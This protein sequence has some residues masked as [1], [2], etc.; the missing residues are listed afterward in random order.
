MSASAA[1][2]RRDWPRWAACG[3]AVLCA[4]A[5]AA[6]IVVNLG[7]PAPS[8]TIEASIV[9]DLAPIATS[10]TQ[11]SQDVAVGPQRPD[12]DGSPEVKS[13]DPTNEKAI[14]HVDMP[15]PVKETPTGAFA[16]SAPRDEKVDAPAEQQ[17]QDQ[18]LREKAPQLQAPAVTAVAPTHKPP[19]PATKKKAARPLQIASAPL[20]EREFDQRVAAPNQGAPAPV[21]RHAAADWQAAISAA[22]ERAKRYPTEARAHQDQGVT[23]VEFNLDRA[24][25]VLSSR[26][27]VSSGYSSLDQ[28]AL[29]TVA[30]ANLPPAP[31]D[32]PGT[33]FSFRVPIQFHIR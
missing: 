19:P 21:G 5:A 8:G 11:Q 13:D 7:E 15:E 27:A 14:D 31:A 28:E 20:P 22:I 24:G 25:H 9:I 16:I 1:R 23:R 4:H 12:I 32:H 29:A 26:V 6:A 2:H 10:P 18:P 17:P 3:V 33:R 30:R